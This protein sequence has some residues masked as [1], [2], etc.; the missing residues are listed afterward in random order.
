MK[1]V[2]RFGAKSEAIRFL[3]YTKLIQLLVLPE[4]DEEKFIATQAAAGRPVEKQSAWEI[5]R[6]VKAFKQQRASEKLSDDDKLPT[7]QELSLSLATPKDTSPESFVR[8]RVHRRFSKV[9]MR[10]FNQ[11][12]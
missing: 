4:D 6:N 11:S 9:N 7:L 10:N 1:P 5:Q 2:R 3:G 8:R 12:L